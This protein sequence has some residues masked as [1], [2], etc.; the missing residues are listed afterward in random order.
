M[1]EEF[2]LEFLLSIGM[3]S[4]VLVIVNSIVLILWDITHRERP[5]QD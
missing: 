1:D 4:S 5:H 3:L 2:L